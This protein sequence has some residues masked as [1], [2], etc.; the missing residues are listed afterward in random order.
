MTHK[1]YILTLCEGTKIDSATLQA[2]TN[3]A[4]NEIRYKVKEY[5]ASGES[6]EKIQEM[7]IKIAAYH[8]AAYHAVTQELVARGIS[9][10][11]QKSEEL[12]TK[13]REEKKSRAIEKNLSHTI[14]EKK[15]KN[16]EK[17]NNHV[18]ADGYTVKERRVLKLVISLIPAGSHPSS[19]GPILEN[20]CKADNIAYNDLL[21]KYDQYG[22]P[23]AV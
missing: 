6:P 5:Q 21:K 1:S 17:A 23:S 20:L 12:K 16:V 3:T 9:I 14:P 19:T 10:K 18:T 4:W 11:Q 8:D 22:P 7:L 2:L 15:K 13:D